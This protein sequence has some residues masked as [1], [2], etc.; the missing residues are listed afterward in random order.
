M[1]DDERLDG[2]AWTGDLTDGDQQDL[3]DFTFGQNVTKLTGEPF[4]SQIHAAWRLERPRT[5]Y[6]FEGIPDQGCLRY[7]PMLRP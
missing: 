7:G 2:R 6:D 1:L 5:A 4:W 3:Q